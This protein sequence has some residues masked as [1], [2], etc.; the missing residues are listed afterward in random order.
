VLVLAGRGYDFTIE[1]QVTD[2]AQCLERSN[3]VGGIVYSECG[4]APRQLAN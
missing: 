4:G 1:G 3:V 2:A